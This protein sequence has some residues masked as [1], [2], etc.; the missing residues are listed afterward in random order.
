MAAFRA[1]KKQ[2]FH[3]LLLNRSA[4]TPFP[5]QLHDKHNPLVDFKVAFC[6]CLKY[7]R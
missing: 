6:V 2:T 5:M 4:R 1:G 3:N 7:S